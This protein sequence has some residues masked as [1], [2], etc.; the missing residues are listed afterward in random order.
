MDSEN[1]ANL[2][3]KQKYSMLLTNVV[4]LQ[5]YKYHSIENS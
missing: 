1:P 4:A 2:I 3:Y 5:N